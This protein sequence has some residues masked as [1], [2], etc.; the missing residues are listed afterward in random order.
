MGILLSL[1]SPIL[2]TLNLCIRWKSPN[3]Q[4]ISR[5][6]ILRLGDAEIPTLRHLGMAIGGLGY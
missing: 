3:P 1:G 4:V 6:E 5:I 2:V